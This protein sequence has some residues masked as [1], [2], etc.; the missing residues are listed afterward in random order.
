MAQIIQPSWD[1][2]REIVASAEERVLICSPYYSSFGIGNVFNSIGNAN[3]FQFWTRLSPNDWVTGATS[4][5][6]LL[7]LADL[8]LQN[9]RDFELAAFERLHAKVYAADYS[10][11]LIGS[12]NLSEGGFRANLELVVKFEGEDA[13]SAI[14]IVENN[15]ANKLRLINLEGFREW[16]QRYEPTILEIRSRPDNSAEDLQDVQRSLDEILGYGQSPQVNGNVEEC[17]HDDFGQW[18]DHHQDLPGAE[19]LSDRYHN[20]SQ[21]NLTGHFK[22]SFYAV[23]GFLFEHN[24]YIAILIRELPQIEPGRV[25]EINTNILDSWLEYFNNHATQSG[26]NYNFAVLRGIL[27]PPVGGTRH[28]GGGGSSTFKRALP[29]VAKYLSEVSCGY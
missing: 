15:F 24:E 28:G 27:P 22:Q 23:V 18:L 3:R 21:Q 12:A 11:A 19:V 9:G 14:R 20:S 29:L 5:N 17:S 8:L 7:A 10:L 4:P 26:N 6:D 16:V 25:Y 13:H 1:N 2:L